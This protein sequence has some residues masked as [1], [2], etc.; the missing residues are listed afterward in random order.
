MA[1]S[2]IFAGMG[3]T[4]VYSTKSNKIVYEKKTTNGI[5]CSKS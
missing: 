1:K 4:A 5:G 3:G 2:L